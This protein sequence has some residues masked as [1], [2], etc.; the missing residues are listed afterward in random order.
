MDYKEI[1]DVD[2]TRFEKCLDMNLW[3]EFPMQNF[4]K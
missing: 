3:V 4:K 1:E 2:R